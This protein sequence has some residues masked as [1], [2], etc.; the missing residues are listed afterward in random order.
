MTVFDP[1]QV[2][3][4]I[5]FRVRRTQKGRRLNLS[6]YSF[7]VYLSLQTTPLDSPRDQVGPHLLPLSVDY[8]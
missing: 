6:V 3:S 1:L 4:N 5:E 2:P 7:G 8:Y